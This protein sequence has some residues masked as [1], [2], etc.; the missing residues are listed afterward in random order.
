M[1]DKNGKLVLRDKEVEVFISELFPDGYEVFYFRR[2]EGKMHDFDGVSD[3]IVSP[4]M[5]IVLKD[6]KSEQLYSFLLKKEAYGFNGFSWWL[7]KTSADG[8][9]FKLRLLQ[10]TDIEKVRGYI[11]KAE[12]PDRLIN[13]YK[14]A[15]IVSIYDG[16]DDGSMQCIHI[17]V[18]DMSDVE[19]GEDGEV[20]NLS[21]GLMSKCKR[22]IKR[23]GF[24]MK[25]S[26][27]YLNDDKS[28][29]I[30]EAVRA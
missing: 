27:M 4:A 20:F 23:A 19:A 8:R 24:V 15:K 25:D 9:K 7:H 5:N 13:I 10:T 29:L 30:L 17:E 22:L 6:T 1:V 14:D 16:L 18:D 2:S 26:F 3:Y 21:K 11:D 12:L 28:Q